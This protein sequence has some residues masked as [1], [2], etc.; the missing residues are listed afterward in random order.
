MGHLWEYDLGQESAT[1]DRWAEYGS[2]RS[3]LIQI[4]PRALIPQPFDPVCVLPNV[5]QSPPAAS[6]RCYNSD[7]LAAAFAQCCCSR[8]KELLAQRPT[9]VVSC[10]PD[11]RGKSLTNSWLALSVPYLCLTHWMGMELRYNNIPEKLNAIA[12]PASTVTNW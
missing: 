7:D 3:D 8:N 1:Y 4:L 2:Q 11:L 10:G 12:K 9:W 5:H 6:A